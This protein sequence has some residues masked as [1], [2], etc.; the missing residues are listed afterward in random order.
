M[1][2]K[3]LTTEV[4]IERSNVIHNNYYEYSQVIVDGSKNKIEVICPVHRFIF[5]YT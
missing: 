1:T 3:K 4:F 5:N 2:T